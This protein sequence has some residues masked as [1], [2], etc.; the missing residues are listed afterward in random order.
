MMKF[1]FMISQLPSLVP[2]LLLAVEKSGHL[3][4]AAHALGVSQPAASKALSRAES[5]LGVALIRRNER[6]LLLTQEGKLVAEFA[7]KQ[8][9]LETALERQIKAIKKSGASSVKIASF[10][11]S[12]STHLLPKLI[13]KLKVFLPA[14]DVQII[15]LH[16]LE[17]INGLK[18]GLVD[19]A[20]VVQDED[21]QL[22]YIPLEKDR[23][24]ALV[25]ANSALALCESLSA[26]DLYKE[27]FIMSK[28]GS[29]A[30]IR[31]WFSA[32]GQQP[33]VKHTALQLTSILGMIRAGMGVSII[34]KMAVPESHPEVAV[35]PL[36]P[37]KPRYICIAKSDREFSS[38]NAMRV[39]QLM[40]RFN[41][42]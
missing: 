39:W 24:T 2:K 13:E 27:D 26:E 20:T 25:P 6:P 10:G 4:D 12:A 8:Q 42:S 3:T 34:A 11:A 40:Q 19:F 41:K 17:L 15:E 35:I 5:L 37:E 18:D 14:L 38:H 32:K 16:G 31:A 30:L 22:E 33:K 1:N 28:G 21:P 36:K 9:D 23:L 29:E 7:Q